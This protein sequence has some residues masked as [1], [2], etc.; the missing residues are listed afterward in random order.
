MVIYMGKAIV[1]IQTRQ[2]AGPSCQE[3]DEEIVSNSKKIEQKFVLPSAHCAQR[4]SL[5]GK[6]KMLSR[7]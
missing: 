6:V 4:P 1:V 2:Q 3:S 7:H 5:Q